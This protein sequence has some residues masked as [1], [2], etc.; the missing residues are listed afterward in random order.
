MR[1][2][3]SLLCIALIVTL[4]M[5]QFPIEV[6]AEEV[7]GGE[8]TIYV[9]IPETHTIQL[10]IGEHGAI[11]ID[12][13]MYTSDA[14]INVKR[15]SNPQFE[16]IADNGYEIDTVYYQNKNVT[17]EISR[18]IYTAPVLFEDGN[19]IKVTFK[20]G[21]E[22]F[23]GSENSGDGSSSGGGNSSN[24]SDTTEG[25]NNSSGSGD[26]NKGD[27]NPSQGENA[28]EE[29]K[30]SDVGGNTG[31]SNNSESQPE[32]KDEVEKDEDNKRKDKLLDELDKIDEQ[33]KNENLSEEERAALKKKKQELIQEITDLIVN[34]KITGTGDIEKNLAYIEKLLA[35]DDLDE[36][37]RSQLQEK[38]NN[39]IKYLEENDD[40][41]YIPVIV[42]SII[43]A[44]V[45]LGIRYSW[46]IKKK[47]TF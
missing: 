39:L 24:G 33:L 11:R 16:I 38:K 14:K 13:K 8:T 7:G 21:M 32:L 47:K 27:N 45:A 20:K 43:V 25:D 34:K 41:S 42:I 40:K 9:H 29:N 35:R 12:G 46:Y 28:G 19:T 23:G 3:K 30:P 1:K 44:G 26:N 2:A 31:G 10:H 17:R 15:L 37:Q 18:N 22:D 4:A 6:N 5:V 36:E